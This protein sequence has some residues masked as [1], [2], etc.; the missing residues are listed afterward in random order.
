MANG[1]GISQRDHT[2]MAEAL[3][4]AGLDESKAK[5]VLKELLK[6]RHML[7]DDSLYHDLY[8]GANT[9]GLPS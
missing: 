3:K 7:I 9:H 2:V 4:A 1:F 5:D 8:V 6:K